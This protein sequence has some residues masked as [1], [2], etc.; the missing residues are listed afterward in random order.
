MLNYRNNQ[1]KY[2]IKLN[3]K[4]T[5]TNLIRFK[6]NSFKYKLKLREKEEFKILEK[7]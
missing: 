5:T 3:L 4:W 7:L 6:I 2:I 1:N